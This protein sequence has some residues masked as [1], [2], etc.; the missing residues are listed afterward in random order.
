VATGK[1]AGLTLWNDVQESLYRYQVSLNT[2]DGIT[3]KV[4]I[5]QI[6]LYG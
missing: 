3:E 4:F 5:F 1:A 6:L 2:D